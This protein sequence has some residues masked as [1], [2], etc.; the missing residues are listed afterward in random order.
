MLLHDPDQRPGAYLICLTY[1][2]KLPVRPDSNTLKLWTNIFCLHLNCSLGG[3]RNP[4]YPS[5]CTELTYS[6]TKSSSRTTRCTLA[7]IRL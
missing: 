7:K 3:R 2:E 4:S 6:S 1:P 5:W